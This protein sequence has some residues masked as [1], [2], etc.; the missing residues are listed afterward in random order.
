MS[1]TAQQLL[2]AVEA[3][4]AEEKATEEAAAAKAKAA[5][6][7][8]AA[9]AA[10]AKKAEEDAK[11]KATDDKG[12]DDKQEP[13]QK[14]DDQDDEAKKQIAE[15]QEKFRAEA[16]KAV[17][18]KLQAE[19]VG[20]GFSADEAAE[21]LPFINCGTIMSDEG[22]V[23]EEKLTTLVDRVSSL[24]LRKPPRGETKDFSSGAGGIG[25][26]LNK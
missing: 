15:L 19:F 11:T 18:S 1:F 5:A 2:A 10:A 20:R 6:E 3:L 12:S 8:D 25:K 14:Q 21:I 24:S 13:E 26:Y 22:E 16:Q 23:D 9:A 17:E 4:A 7:A